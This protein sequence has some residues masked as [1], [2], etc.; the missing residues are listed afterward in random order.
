MHLSTLND[1]ELTYCTNVHA[2]ESLAEVRA[3]VRE[4]VTAVKRLVAPS[5]PFGVGLRLA[6]AA[7]EELQQPQALAEFRAELADLGLYC[8]TLNGFPYGAFHATRVKESVYEPDWLSPA[9]A[10]YT[11]HLASTLAELLPQGV[12]GSISTVPGCFKPNAAAPEAERAMAFALIDMV[13]VLS[14]IARSKGRHIALA[15]E[16]EPECFLETTDEAVRFFE[17]QLLG[18]AALSRL[19]EAADLEPSQ[20][21]SV[22]RRH[23]GVCLDTCHASVEFESPLAAYRKLGAAGIAVPK[24]QLSAGLRI[25][26]ATPEALSRLH[27]FADGVYLHQTVVKA[28]AELRRYLDLPDALAAPP[29]PGAEWR[30]HFHV[31]IFMRELG[32]FESTQS[33]LLPLLAELAQAPSCPHLEVETYTWDVLPDEFRNVPIEQA[34]A[35]EL[36]FVLNALGSAAAGRA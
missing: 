3:L 26:S 17:Q 21:E 6:A 18:R 2:G 12:S 14:D 27:A 13:A 11:R 9:R 15:L 19:A 35:R 4:H 28:G 36:G 20:A 34:I 25:P 10:R 29:E 32:V 22:L 33:D 23:I 31:P 16:P 1:A 24:V 30:V 8:F 7:A 5:I